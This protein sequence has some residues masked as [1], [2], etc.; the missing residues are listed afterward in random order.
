[1]LVLS[2]AN[3]LK[4][5]VVFLYQTMAEMSV[6]WAVVNLFQYTNNSINFLLYC[7]SGSRFR[8]ELRAMFR[9]KFRV[10]PMNFSQTNQTEV[11]LTRCV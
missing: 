11:P 7:L 4:T 9:R 10:A 5:M 8:E 6:A 3:A 2:V 1:M